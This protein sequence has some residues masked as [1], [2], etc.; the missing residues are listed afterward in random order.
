MQLVLLMRG[1]KKVNIDSHINGCII[2]DATLSIA[3]QKLAIS[4][5]SLK[6]MLEINTSTLFSNNCAMFCF[7]L[8]RNKFMIDTLKILYCL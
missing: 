6:L 8:K 4:N 7:L 5:F 2:F 1:I 3:V